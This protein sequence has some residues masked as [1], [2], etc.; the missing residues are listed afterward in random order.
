MPAE[1]ASNSAKKHESATAVTRDDTAAVTCHPLRTLAARHRA[2]RPMLGYMRM[3]LRR[4]AFVLPNLFT[5]GS[6]FCGFYAITAAFGGRGEEPLYQ[7]A[8]AILIGTFF[9]AFDGRVARM[10]RTQTALGLQLDSLADV[11]TFGVAPAALVYNWSLEQLGVTGLIICFGWIAAGA[12][13]LARFN[14]LALAADTGPGKYIIGLPI[15]AAA[16]VIVALVIVAHHADSGATS[17]GLA[18]IVASLS[19]LM[20]SR[21]RFRSFK[22]V[23]W[24]SRRTVMGIALVTVGSVAVWVGLRGAY[25]FLFL[26]TL[27]IGLGLAETILARGRAHDASRHAV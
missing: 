9:D 10:T 26:I 11:V 24:G 6:L 7:A 4:V 13:R 20:V 18:L 2:E 5:L 21:V 22:A 19:L 14:V 27:Y 23:A 8:L 15:P 25:V 16:A 17:P 3:H 12:L 1:A